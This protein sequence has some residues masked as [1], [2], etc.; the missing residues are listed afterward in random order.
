MSAT[1]PDVRAGPTDRSLS[2]EATV[3]V[4]RALSVRIG[5][6]PTSVVAAV[7]SR[8]GA[9]RIGEAG[10]EGNSTE[11]TNARARSCRAACYSDRDMRV[12]MSNPHPGLLCVYARLAY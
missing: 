10:E 8:I 1:R 3:V 11:K 9:E 4:R 6:C 7:S 5:V 2:P 12:N